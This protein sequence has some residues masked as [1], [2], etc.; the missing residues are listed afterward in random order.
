MFQ[1]NEVFHVY[2]SSYLQ[3]AIQMDMACYKLLT[4]WLSIAKSY[5][6][7]ITIDWLLLLAMHCPIIQFVQSQLINQPLEYITL[8]ELEI[9]SLILASYI[10][11]TKMLHLVTISHKS[12]N[13]LYKIKLLLQVPLH[14][15]CM[16]TYAQSI[17]FILNT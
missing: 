14:I 2:Y 9:L 3:Y 10:F 12:L 7:V 13:F 4:V 8:I 17:C 15:I 1:H 6:R 11:K 16:G 5:T